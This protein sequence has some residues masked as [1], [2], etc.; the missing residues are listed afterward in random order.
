LA[1]IVPVALVT[2]Y[3]VVWASFVQDRG[4]PEG[5]VRA[6]DFVPIFTGALILR[7]G[8]GPLLF[9]LET[10]R[11]VQDRVVGSS[12]AR[13][14]PYDRVPF[15]ALLVQPFAIAPM[16]VAFAAWTLIAGLALGLAVGTMDGA[17]PVSR[18]VG[19]VLSLAACSYLPAIRGLMLGQ[20]S[21]FVL[22]GLCGT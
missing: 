1:L 22:M 16:W 3:L 19:W 9:D 18:P 10:Q 6:T 8:D 17:L 12:N 4:G 20:D 15:E 11:V 13:L 2:T 14:V 21:L 7:G 5:Y